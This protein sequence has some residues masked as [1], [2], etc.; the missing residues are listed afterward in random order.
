MSFPYI[1]LNSRETRLRQRAHLFSTLHQWMVS[2]QG[3]LEISL[4]SVTPD[5]STNGLSAD[6]GDWIA[7]TTNPIDEMVSTIQP[8]PDM[9]STVVMAHPE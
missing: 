1:E 8:Q 9:E 3:Q 2:I 5:L 6:L 4:L 7:E